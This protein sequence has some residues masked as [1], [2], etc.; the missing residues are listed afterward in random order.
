[1]T[2]Y[3]VKQLNERQKDEFISR[4]LMSKGV[5]WGSVNGCG[6]RNAAKIVTVEQCEREL[7][8]IVVRYH[9]HLVKNQSEI[10]ELIYRLKQVRARAH[11]K[12]DE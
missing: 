5:D 2:E 11:Q 10:N 12:S 9:H 3:D 1:M 6:L 4:W 8:E 7:L